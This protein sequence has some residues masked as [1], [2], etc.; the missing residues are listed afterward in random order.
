MLYKGFHSYW[1]R[2]IAEGKPTFLAGCKETSEVVFCHALFQQIREQGLNLDEL[3]SY[4]HAQDRLKQSSEG[5][6]SQPDSKDRSND[7]AAVSAT[8]AYKVVDAML[9]MLPCE[10][11]LDVEKRI[12][13][14]RFNYFNVSLQVFPPLDPMLPFPRW[15]SHE[16]RQTLLGVVAPRK[17][18]AGV[19]FS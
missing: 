1:L 15:K 17:S 16:C 14:S 4:M 7:G 13:S 5:K 2:H 8:L 3:A 9:N 12:S 19:I 6:P 18:V 10:S 11:V